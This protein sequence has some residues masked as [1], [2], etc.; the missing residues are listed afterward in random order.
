MTLLEENVSLFAQAPAIPGDVV[1]D[2]ASHNCSEIILIL[3][4]QKSSVF[5]SQLT[6]LTRLSHLSFMVQV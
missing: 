6:R 5:E 4:S 1:G 3:S 2:L